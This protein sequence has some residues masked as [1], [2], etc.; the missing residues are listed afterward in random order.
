M[1]IRVLQ[2]FLTVV[3]RFSVRGHYPCLKSMVTDEK[4][5]LDL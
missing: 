2:Y 1:E 4:Q 3:S 5:V